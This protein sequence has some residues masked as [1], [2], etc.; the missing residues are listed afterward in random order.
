MKRKHITIIS[1]LLIL[2]IGVA[3]RSPAIK[4]L[5]AHKPPSLPAPI[6]VSASET[7]MVTRTV[8]GDTFVVWL[9]GTEEK[10]RMLG[11]DTPETVDPRKPVQCFGKEASHR[12][13][14][15]LTGVVVRLE[16]DPTNDNRDKY[17]RILRY[18][19]LPDGTDV[20]AQMIQQGYA[21]AYTVFPFQKR[22]AYLK[23]QTD[24]RQNARGLWALTTCAGKHG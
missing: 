22:E 12:L 5:I 7:D 11:M 16:P 14:D 24:A 3:I 17:N 8:D 13:H 20:N 18:V 6:I 2:L 21:F 10:V 23:L 15:L 9:N 19:Y 1:T 4:N